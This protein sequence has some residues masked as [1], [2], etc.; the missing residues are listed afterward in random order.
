MPFSSPKCRAEVERII[1][2]SLEQ[3]AE[4]GATPV[5]LSDLAD[6][7]DAFRDGSYNVA[8][9][10]G[11]ASLRTKAGSEA[12]RPLTMARSLTDLLRDFRQ[13]AALDAT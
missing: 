8:I 6:A 7:I 13:V 5:Q 9:E 3:M 11:L 4:R 2:F 12:M 10:L 1:A